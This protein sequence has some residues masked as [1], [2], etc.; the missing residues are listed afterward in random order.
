[1]AFVSW[2]DN[3]VEG[4]TNERPDVFVYDRYTGAIARVSVASDG[5]QSDGFS[6]GGTMSAHGRWIAFGS[7][8]QSL[9]PDPVGWE[10]DTF[11]HDRQTGQTEWIDLSG[12]GAGGRRSIT[13]SPSSLS[14]DGRYLALAALTGDQGTWHVYVHDRWTGESERISEGPDGT[15]GDGWSTVPVLSAD[16]RYVAFWSWAG[17]LVAGD[18]RACGEAGEP[19][20]CGDVFVY[21]REAE[22]MERIPVGEGYGLGGGGYELSLSA[23]GQYLV[24]RGSI[25]DRRTQTL[26]S[27]CGLDAE[28]QSA[29][30]SSAMSA[31]GRWIAYTDGQVYLCDREAGTIVPVSVAA[32]GAAGDAMG[33]GPSGI[34]YGH[35]GYSGGLDLSADGRWLAFSSQAGNLVPGEDKDER[36][37]ERLAV[38]PGAPHCYDVYLYDRETGAMDKV[39]EPGM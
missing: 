17:N 35:E 6:G 5:T 27:Y 36:C 13:S 2:A 31:D 34:V 18:E 37:Q 32:D 7:E 21:D 39:G 15:P 20:S 10:W 8:A 25:Y 4:D 19:R 14:A 30:Q 3:L 26:A 33:D 9:E 23:D 16:G 29:V 38:L 11:V 28:A 1:V 12:E 22:R 24:Y